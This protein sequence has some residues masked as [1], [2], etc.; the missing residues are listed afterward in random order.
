M[1]KEFFEAFTNRVSSPLFGYFVFSVFAIN[2]KAITLLLFSKTAIS[3]R[4]ALFDETTSSYSLIILPLLIA[5][6]AAVIY[7]WINLLFLHISKAPTYRRNVLQAKSEHELLTTKIKLEKIRNQLLTIKE[8]E[9]IDRA[10]RDEKLGKIDDVALRHKLENEIEMLRKE[11][12]SIS[13]KN[14]NK[15]NESIENKQHLLELLEIHKKTAERARGG[16]DAGLLESSFKKIQE[17]EE[18]LSM[19][20]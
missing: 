6:S 19:L 4:I 10:Q 3:L 12:D 5:I 13:E 1:V 14:K 9:L 17:I 16:E 8:D 7:P 20:N 2:W 18:K 15:S 11:K